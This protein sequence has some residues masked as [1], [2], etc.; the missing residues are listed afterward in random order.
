M[1]KAIFLILV[2]ASLASAASKPFIGINHRMIKEIPEIKHMPNVNGGIQITSVQKGTPADHAGLLAGDIIIGIAGTY[3]TQ[4]FD[5][6]P[7][8]FKNVLYQFKPEDQIDLTV[9]RLEMFQQ[10]EI[11]NKIVKSEEYVL[12]PQAY[13][14]SLPAGVSLEFIS[15]KDWKWFDLEI[16]LGTRPELSLSPPPSIADTDLG[17]K[18]N[19]QT[20]KEYTNWQPVVDEVVNRYKISEEFNDLRRRLQNIESGDDGTRLPAVAEVHRNPYFLEYYGRN[21]VESF[22][23]EDRKVSDYF[24]TLSMF[25]TGNYNPRPDRF[26]ASLPT[27]TLTG[28]HP[29]AIDETYFKQWFEIQMSMLIA[30][31]LEAYADLTEEERLFF[32]EHRYDLTDAFALGIYIQ[33]DEDQKR[34]ER[35]LKLLDICKKIDIDKLAVAAACISDFLQMNETRIFS[36]MLANP[37]VR[38]IETKWGKIGF[39][40][41]QRERWT[42]SDYKYIFDPGGND[43]Y[44]NGTGAAKSFNQPVSWIIDRD[45]D[46]A[47]QA[48]EDG[49][50]ACGNPGIGIIIDN[51]GDDTYIGHRWSQGTGY[52]GVGILIDR[53][54]DD[55]YVGTE[56]NQGAGLFGFGLLYDRKGND[57]YRASV[58]GQGFGLTHG[59]GCLYDGSGNDYGFCTGKHPTNYGDAGIFDAWSQGCGMGFR[60]IASGGI[61][62]VIDNDGRDK[63]QAGN[64]SQGGGYYYGLGIFAANGG[65]DDEYIASRYGQGFC[66][67]QAAGLFIDDG[68]DDYYTTRQGVV[69]GLAWDECVTVFV[70][71]DGDDHYMGGTGFS[72]GAS[73]HNSFCVFID[74]EGEDYYD[75]KPGPARAGGNDYHGGFSFSLFLDLDDDQDTYTSPKGGNDIERAWKEYGVFRDGEGIPAEPIVKP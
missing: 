5:S 9:A 56:Y 75:Y 4:P 63:W 13:V 65:D 27:I 31:I 26:Y 61:G 53:D 22:P 7:D 45:G 70:D 44:A 47:Y 59:L 46:D 6:I 32:I 29:Q 10:L 8:V 1:R 52:A 58:Y 30:Q 51:D 11:D 57:M 19:V 74:Y 15:S 39:G 73:A 60:S 48:T 3:F 20:N 62:L 36:W 14:E 43:F 2:L 49:S 33:S 12:D 18:L 23:R 66:A 67:H 37:D 68:G 50:I 21:L 38:E 71:E 28:S 55:E 35:N 54:G 69:T 42:K 40:T 34:F 16:N 17:K 72:H 24:P 25:L 41:E 64:F